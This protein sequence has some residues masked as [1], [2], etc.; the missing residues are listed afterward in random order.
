MWFLVTHCALALIV[1]SVA[2]QLCTEAG[3]TLVELMERSLATH[4]ESRRHTLRAIEMMEGGE[5]WTRLNG[6]DTTQQDLAA[7]RER[8]VELDRVITLYEARIAQ[9]GGIDGGG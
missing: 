9:G 1:G 5:M 8:L 2:D 4:R 7:A 3:A 6:E